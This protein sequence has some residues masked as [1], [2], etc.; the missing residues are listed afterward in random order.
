VGKRLESGMEN[1]RR[2]K[3]RLATNNRLF[4]L[5]HMDFVVDGHIALG[6]SL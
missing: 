4:V 3:E 2:R 6:M 5:I 1:I